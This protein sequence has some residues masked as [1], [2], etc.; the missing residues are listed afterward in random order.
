MTGT[1]DSSMV[2]QVRH[3]PYACVVLGPNQIVVGN[4]GDNILEVL[5]SSIDV[6]YIAEDGIMT[7]F[8]VQY[9][10]VGSSVEPF[11]SNPNAR[12]DA[13][14]NLARLNTRAKLAEQDPFSLDYVYQ[15]LPDP[16]RGVDI[17][18]VDTGLFF[19]LSPNLESISTSTSEGVFVDHVRE[20][21]SIICSSINLR[22]A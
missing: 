2:S 20:H 22:I 19:F 9:V 3:L 14:W 18:V 21:C 11:Y 7:T 16:G 12:N 8:D 1:L 6:E 10:E 4:F 17:Y 13:P 15:Y 5:K